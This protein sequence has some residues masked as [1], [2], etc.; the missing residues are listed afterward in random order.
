MFFASVRVTATIAPAVRYTF[1]YGKGGYH[2][3]KRTAEL[4]SFNFAFCILHFAFIRPARVDKK[5]TILL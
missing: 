4:V 5:V 1:S 2:H 3:P